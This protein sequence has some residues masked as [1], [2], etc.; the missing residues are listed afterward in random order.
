M[1]AQKHAQPQT[2]TRP[3]QELRGHR[4]ATRVPAMTVEEA[5]ALRD[6][7]ASRGVQVPLEITAAGVV[8]D[9]RMR[10]QAALSLGLETV[11]VRVLQPPDEVEYM[12][13]AALHRCHL[14]PSQRAALA[15]E[16]REYREWA[17]RAEARKRAN[18]RHSSVDVAALPDRGGRSR[19]HAARLAGV[20]PR[21]IQ[22][23]ITVRDRDPVLYEQ[24][25]AGGVTLE[26]AVKQIE[27]Q[28]RYATI[29]SPSPL[30]E[31]SFD[32]I[33]ADPPWQLGS[34]TSPNSPEQHYPT[35]PTRE[36]AELAVPAAEQAVLFLW[37]VSSLLP[38]ALEVIDAWGF[39][40]KT[41]LVWVKPW[42]GLGNYVR[43]RHELLLLA[44]R[45]GC[46]TPPPDRRPDSV[47]EAPRGRH[48]EKPARFYK[49]IERMDP[50]A[51]RLELF[52][53]GKPRSGWTVWGNEAT[54]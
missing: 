27:R 54:P 7:I 5:A 12:L 30:P 9:G 15:L 43:N 14:K 23:A 38:D 50:Q 21:L 47:V 44:T 26:Q 45:G 34:P 33:Y 42:I 37:A 36:I 53:R 4:E 20:S 46:P 11:P 48:S 49:L 40:Y 8:L 13:L 41:S 39:T 10:H 17:V 51:R 2:D 35:L 6:D 22:H 1:R 32:L 29:E 16:L 52:A 3:P 18:L 28:E 31:G 24:A 19:D 25:K